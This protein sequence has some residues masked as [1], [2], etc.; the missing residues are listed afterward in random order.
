MRR[1]AAGRRFASAADTNLSNAPRPRPPRR[2]RNVFRARVI[3]SEGPARESR[4]NLEGRGPRANSCILT[5]TLRR[6]EAM[7]VFH[8]HTVKCVCGNTLTVQLAD[9]INVKRAPDLR[10]RILRGELHRAACPACGRQMTRAKSF[11]RQ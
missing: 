1:V 6:S 10:E 2:G 7:A 8:P 4:A 5:R 9:S 11:S 3:K